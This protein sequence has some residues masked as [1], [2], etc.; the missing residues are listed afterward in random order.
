MKYDRLIA[1]LNSASSCTQLT[2]MPQWS[3]GK[4]PGSKPDFTEDPSSIGHRCGMYLQKKSSKKEKECVVAYVPHFLA[5][6]SD[7]S[8]AFCYELPHKSKRGRSVEPCAGLAGWGRTL[9][10]PLTFLAS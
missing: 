2:E 8:C 3:S 10:Q 4:A 5:V 7:N 9:L 1:T 6:L